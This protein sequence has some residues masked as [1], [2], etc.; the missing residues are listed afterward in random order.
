[1]ESLG[2]IRFHL[3]MLNFEVARGY[4]RNNVLDIQLIIEIETSGERAHMR[5]WITV[6]LA[7]LER[8]LEKIDTT[9]DLLQE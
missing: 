4:Q 3:V 6:C 8:H 1:M 2:G 7:H 5:I 9:E